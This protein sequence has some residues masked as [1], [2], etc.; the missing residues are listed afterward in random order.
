MI[1]NQDW[2]SGNIFLRPSTMQRGDVIPGHS[3]NFDHTHFTQSGWFLVRGW[4][5][6]HEVVH[7]KASIEYR[8]LRNLRLQYEPKSVLR[9]IRFPDHTSAEK[10]QFNIQF[11]NQGEEVPE[12]GS[13][14]IFAPTGYHCL[15]MAHTFHDMIALD[16]GHGDCVYSHREPQGEIALTRNGWDEAYV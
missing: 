12:G 4:V 8:Q 6:G 3:H 14:I 11:I 2:V 15:I 9:P 10:Q 7:Q 13:E 1:S 5:N 16:D